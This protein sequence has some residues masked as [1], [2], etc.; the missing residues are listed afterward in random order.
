[1]AS[2]S[3]KNDGKQKL[4]SDATQA[5][6]AVSDI[7]QDKGASAWNR[8][9]GCTEGAR[10]ASTNVY[11]PIPTDAASEKASRGAH[12][13]LPQTPGPASTSVMPIDASRAA[14]GAHRQPAM[15][16]SD[17]AYD[18]FARSRKSNAG[19]A[20]GITVGAVVL[21]AV[22]VYI[23]GA[24]VFMG[25][26][27]PN[28]SMGEL[29]LSF[30]SADE[31]AALLAEAESDYTLR[32]EGQGLGFS[33][34]SEQAGVGV[35]ARSI[36]DAALGDSDPWKWP[37]RIIGSHDETERMVA[38]SD[39]EALSAAV[40]EAVDAFNET[41]E[42]SADAYVAF[43]DEKGAY[44]VHEEV[45]GSQV[46]ADEVIARVSEAVASMQ[47]AVTLD[48]GV[49]IEPA[50]LSDDERLASAAD[51]ANVMIGCDVVL[52]SS[53]DGTE[54][55]ELDGSVISQWIAFD[56][57]LEPVLDAKALDAWAQELAASLNTVGTVRSYTRPDGRHVEI[58]G[59]DYG[60]Q[61]DSDALIAA[62]KDAVN[63]GTV[64]EL[65]IPCSSTGNGYTA[66]GQDWSAYCDID[67]AEQHA[68]YYD[69][70]GALLWDAPIVSGKPN[71]EDDTPTGVYYLKNL[72]QGVSLKGPIDPETNKPEWDSPVDYWMPFVGN[73]VGLHDAPW[74]PSSVFGN[75]EAYK[76]YGSHG[77]VNLSPDKA[78]EL[79]GVIQIGD[80]VIVHW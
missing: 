22:V 61:V 45:R 11:R 76:T 72:Q 30:K 78:G 59:G 2:V 12:A 32:V 36:V 39:A 68:Y 26:F 4:P 9:P 71:G 58:G 64:G 25:R 42:P 3:S 24:V 73:M 19:K 49:L 67:L 51:K 74:Q 77:C 41:A 53:T 69:A 23:A 28:T 5:M 37:L 14:H 33:I 63:S 66:P 1:M 10:P 38:G 27:Y 48:A 15:P 47:D 57:N 75:A 35:D 79:F 46:S 52:K 80:A 50:V 17:S 13:R 60:W 40:H 8:R 43:D 44:A 56:E 18:G 29:D 16:V 21:L 31:A 7:H 65:N 54:I 20:I 6:P 55:S 34:S 62:V 70:S